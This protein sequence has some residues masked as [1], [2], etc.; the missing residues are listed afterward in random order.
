[1]TRTLRAH[2]DGSVIV[3]AE[4]VDL[5]I[6]CP[7]ELEL[8]PVTSISEESADAKTPPL[9]SQFPPNEAALAALQQLDQLQRGMNPKSGG[10]S[11]AYIREARSGALYG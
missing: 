1:M 5:P 3:P 6:D 8:K 9:Q 2:F 7:L 10:D 4:P 11:Q